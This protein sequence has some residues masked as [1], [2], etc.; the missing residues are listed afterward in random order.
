MKDKPIINIVGTECQPEYEEEFNKWYDEVHIPLLLKFRGL[1]KAR[2][3]KIIGGGKGCP[4][5]LAVYEFESQQA[6][7]EYGTSQELAA[8]L[9]D[10]KITW[11]GREFELSMRVQYGLI[12]S[13]NK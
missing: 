8:A 9:E 5:Y 6:F 3:Y 12:G 4:Q 1:K 2:R 13:W 7:E 11:K 10:M